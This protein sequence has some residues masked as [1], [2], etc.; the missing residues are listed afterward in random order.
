MAH[1]QKIRAV[2]FYLSVLIFIAGLPFILSFALGYKFNSRTLKF[3]KTG[4]I[5]LVTEPSG[6][7]IYLDNK[8]LNE[9]TPATIRELLPGNYNI[10]LALAK[11]YQ[12]KSQVSVE[13]GK[14]TRLDRII[15]FPL[16]PNIK[17][18]N[19]EKIYSFWVDK[20][21]KK[22]YYIDQKNSIIYK[23]DS[24]GENF[25]EIGR[26]PQ[27]DYPPKQ[28]KISRDK[29]KLLCFNLRQIAIVYLNTQNGLPYIE[30]PFVLNFPALRIINVFWH[31]DSYHL[32]LITDRSIEVLEARPN[33]T[34]VDL[35]NLN[36]TTA[37]AYYDDTDDS[38]YFLDSQKAADG[39]LYDNVYK[40]E[41]SQKFSTFKELMKPRTDER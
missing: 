40:L 30:L 7:S 36:K 25:E 6:A 18:L 9:N 39:K 5:D 21:K 12:W 28:W 33:S 16:R 19:K 37:F 35:V 34:P 14:V 20:E 24:D 3:T 38:L 1:E 11:H 22:I 17:H 29:D 26:I 15:L 8:L 32:I 2:L 31:S 4:L 27:M 10:T 23:S 13:A 41:L